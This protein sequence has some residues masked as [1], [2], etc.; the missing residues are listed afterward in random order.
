MSWV[1]PLGLA[2]GVGNKGDAPT[3][4]TPSEFAR[5]W[6]GSGQY[7]GVDHFRDITVK[8][9]TILMAGAPGQ[10]NFYTTVRAIERRGYSKEG[11]FKGL[12]VFPHEQFGYR[13]GMT[14]YRVLEDTPAA[15]SI[16]RANPKAGPGG[17]PQIV[18]EK[19]EG[20]LEPLYS[21]KLK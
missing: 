1:D 14:A 11:V 4:Q 7:P 16:V 12:Q 20:M 13:P 18:I 17:L 8:K 21:V 19:Y 10:G 2:G 6:Q 5:G 3:Q 9:G 15:F